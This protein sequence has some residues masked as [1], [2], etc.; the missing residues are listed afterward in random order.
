MRKL[1]EHL[2]QESKIKTQKLE[3]KKMAGTQPSNQ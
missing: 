3:I 1:L 2:F